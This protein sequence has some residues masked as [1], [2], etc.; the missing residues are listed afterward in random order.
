[1]YT[2]IIRTIANKQEWKIDSAMLADVDVEE[3]RS[4]ICMRLTDA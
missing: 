1:M 4:N 3:L 2:F